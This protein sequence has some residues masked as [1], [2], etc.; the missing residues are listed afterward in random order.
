MNDGALAAPRRELDATG[1]GLAMIM[2]EL[3]HGVLVASATGQ[4]LHANQAA[5][6]ELARRQILTVQEGKLQTAD[7]RQSRVLLQALEKAESGLRSLI[8][9]RSPTGRL[10]IAVVP[11]RSQQPRPRVPIALFLSRAS[12]C[13]ALMLCFFARSHGLTPAEEQVLS[14]LC[15]G[16]SAPEIAAQLNVAVSTVRSHIRS[17]CTKTHTNGVRALVG[18]VAVLP[19]LGAAFLQDPPH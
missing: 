3:A 12:V 8:A 9:L 7:A 18:Q 6:H 19:P 15:Q 2:D 1:S 4:L 14:I 17:L 10:S 11:L 13:D 5:R 16:Y